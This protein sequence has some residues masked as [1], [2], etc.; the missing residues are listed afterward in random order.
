MPGYAVTRTQ[1]ALPIGSMQPW[2]GDLSDIPAGWLLCNN[3]EL[4]AGDYP[5]LARVLRDTYG[6]TSFQGTFPNYTGTFRLPPMNDKAAADI[7]T[8]YFGLYSG[9]NVDAWSAGAT[10]YD[11]D[12]IV[13]SGKYYLVQLTDSTAASGTLGTTAP[14]H[15]S[16]TQSN[17]T[18]VNLKAETIVAGAVPSPI[19]NPAALNIVRN[20]IGDSIGGFEPGDLGPPNVQNA[21]TDISLKYVPDPNGTIVA[22]S[23]AGTAPSVSSA[24]VYTVSGDDVEPTTNSNSGDSVT[25]TGAAFLVVINT[26]GSYSVATKQ[27]GSGYEIGDQLKIEGDVFSADGG[28]ASTNDLTITINQVGDSYFEGT[29][30]GQSIIKGFGIKDV[31]II[32][33]KLGRF[34]MAQHFHEGLYNTLNYNDASDRPGNGACVFATPDFTFADFASRRNPCPPEQ[35]LGIGCPIDVPLE[36]IC[37]ANPGVYI[38]SNKT[39]ITNMQT[40][41]FTAGVGR[42]AIAI[43]GG[44]LPLKGYIPAGTAQAGHGVGKSWFDA[45]TVKNLRDAANQTSIS[46][47]ANK[48]GSA[49]QKL[50]WLKQE[51]EFFPGFTVPFSDSSQA[52]ATP[53]VLKKIDNNDPGGV[54]HGPFPVLFNHA[55]T[56]F[57]NDT[58]QNTF[59]S[60]DIIESHD[61]DGSF[62]VQYDGTNIDV[63]EQIQVKAQPVV[64]PDNIPNALQI[65]FTTRVASLTMTN[66]IRAY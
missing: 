15:T 66:L 44:G 35:P 41:P 37:S 47:T 38:G 29:I 21:L 61:H 4:N 63:S 50:A 2:G 24:K 33:R 57:L 48:T 40:S 51:G 64:T 11:G 32:P 3:Q 65:R 13:S 27:K 25:G 45:G 14:T 12:I 5:L 55:A 16:G 53:N 30:T 23:S 52:V 36:L 28:V 56:D 54:D 49:G 1:R 59:G 19:D 62:S 34:H 7:S 6:G 9:S 43:A 60:V 8:G 22:V 42:Y 17:S 39:Q 18:S 31:Y 58:V 26:D 20:Y 10:V 46:Q